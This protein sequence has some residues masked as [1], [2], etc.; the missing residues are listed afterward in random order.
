MPKPPFSGKA[1]PA[2]HDNAWIPRKT[3]FLAAGRV[4]IDAASGQWSLS[5]NAEACLPK[6]GTGF[7]IKMR[8]QEIKA[9]R[10]NTI[11]HDMFLGYGVSG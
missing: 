9:C 1:H 2:C 7:G 5:S 6:A 10:L 8:K 3:R 11:K 4:G